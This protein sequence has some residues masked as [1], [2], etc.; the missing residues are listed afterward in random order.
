MLSEGLESPN[1]AS[2]SVRAGGG[3]PAPVKEDSTTLPTSA[4][5][6]RTAPPPHP[7]SRGVRSSRVRGGT[8]GRSPPA[9]AR[10][11]SSDEGRKRRRLEAGGSRPETGGWGLGTGDL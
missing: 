1:E 4:R 10:A 11:G 7:Q 6:Q 3:T 9:P 5:D 8:R 2:A